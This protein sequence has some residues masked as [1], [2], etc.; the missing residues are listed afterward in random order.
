MA[1]D[2]S[3]RVNSLGLLHTHFLLTISLPMDEI[4]KGCCHS[5]DV[6]IR[7]VFKLGNHGSRYSASRNLIHLSGFSTL[8]CPLIAMTLSDTDADAGEQVFILSHP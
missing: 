1:L 3:P 5:Q 7:R 4:P 8:L 2:M 6:P